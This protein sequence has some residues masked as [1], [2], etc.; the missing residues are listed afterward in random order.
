MSVFFDWRRR[1][2]KLLLAT[3][4]SLLRRSPATKCNP[5]MLRMFDFPFFPQTRA[6][7]VAV[8]RK[9]QPYGLRRIAFLWRRR[10]DSPNSGASECTH[11]A[12]R[13]TKSSATLLPTAFYAV[14]SLSPKQKS[15]HLSA[16]FVAEK[17]RFELLN[18][19]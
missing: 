17:K 5:T 12:K 11:K 8:K 19:F 2:R 1:R 9:K 14:E 13:A 4:I 18:R 6:S 10:R 16:I 7:T 15:T 3:N